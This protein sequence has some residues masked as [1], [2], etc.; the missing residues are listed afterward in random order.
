[1]KFSI[2][3][4]FSEYDQIRRKL[5]EDPKNI[6]LLKKSLMENF[7]FCAVYQMFESLEKIVNL[8][9]IICYLDHVWLIF[10]L[11][12]K[13]KNG[14]TWC[15]IFT[16]KNVHATVFFFLKNELFAGEFEIM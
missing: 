9:S 8:F 2:K 10:Y 7:V 1:M 16:W 5:S 12:N 14:N 11:V 4:F 15:V 13:I 6:H 3:Y